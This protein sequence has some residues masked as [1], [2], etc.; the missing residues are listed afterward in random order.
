MGMTLWI[1]IDLNLSL[2]LSLSYSPTGLFTMVAALNEGMYPPEMEWAMGHRHGHAQQDRNRTQQC[3]VRTRTYM[4]VYAYIRYINIV[5][6]DKAH[7][8]SHGRS[9]GVVYKTHAH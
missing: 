1:L 8:R 3:D 6:E 7:V 4:Y 9:K 5:V 2:S